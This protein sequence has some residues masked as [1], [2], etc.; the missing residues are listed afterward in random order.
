MCGFSWKINI[1]PSAEQ[2][3]WRKQLLEKAVHLAQ[4]NAVCF[5]FSQIN[6]SFTSQIFIYLYIF[7]LITLPII[8]KAIKTQKRDPRK[9]PQHSW[10][11]LSVLPAFLPKH[12]GGR[13][14]CANT[15]TLRSHRGANHGW[16]RM[17][18]P[19][20]FQ[21]IQGLERSPS[22][23]CPSTVSMGVHEMP[24]TNQNKPI[25]KMRGKKAN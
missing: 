9:H 11:A 17:I 5:I 16:I 18:Q 20:R 19:N 2:R 8:F 24:S 23:L 13:Q 3:R 6:F 21:W 14:P 7:F 15:T 12:R 1:R 25:L 10:A 22:G 4:A